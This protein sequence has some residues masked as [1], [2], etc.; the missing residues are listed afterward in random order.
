MM[1][2]YEALLAELNEHGFARRTREQ[3]LQCF[4]NPAMMLDFMQAHGASLRSSA[5]SKDVVFFTTP[6]VPGEDPT[7]PYER[8]MGLLVQLEQL[9]THAARELA[10]LG[11]SL[12]HLPQEQQDTL[13]CKAIAV[14]VRMNQLGKLYGK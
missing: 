13:L 5:V 1:T 7:T 14:T 6:V 10:A 8:G 4:T 9:F 11:D 12:E 2:A 3:L